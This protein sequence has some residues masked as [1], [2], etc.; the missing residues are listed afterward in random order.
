MEWQ[1]FINANQRIYKLRKR[2][3]SVMP[4]LY[5]LGHIYGDFTKLSLLLIGL[6]IIH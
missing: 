1:G 5:M 4:Q 6:A 3:K 2:I